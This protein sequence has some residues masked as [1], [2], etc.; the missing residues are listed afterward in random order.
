[1]VVNKLAVFANLNYHL[2]NKIFSAK[3]MTKF[4][5]LRVLITARLLQ[6]EF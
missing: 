6:V 4:E 5:D 1:M 2:R 3:S